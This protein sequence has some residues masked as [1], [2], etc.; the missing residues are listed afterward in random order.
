MNSPHSHQSGILLT[1]WSYLFAFYF[2]FTLP[3]FF[4][5]TLSSS[6]S[7]SLSLCLS[8]PF[9]LSCYW[10]LSACLVC[11]LLCS[12]LSLFF[13]APFFHRDQR[14]SPLLSSISHHR[15]LALSPHHPLLL[16]PSCPTLLSQASDYT[17]AFI[18]FEV[19]RKSS[20]S[21]RLCLLSSMMTG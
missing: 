21:R 3:L 10:E 2:I 18:P 16:A 1:S 9:S 11:N 14:A 8:L 19:N 6:L 7:I 20:G 12:P 15:V 5:L 17:R 4:S 13:S